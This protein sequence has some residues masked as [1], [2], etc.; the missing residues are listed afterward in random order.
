M[1][2]YVL[3][4]GCVSK[5]VRNITD[6]MCRM[7]DIFMKEKTVRYAKNVR[8]S[9][10]PMHC[11]YMESAKQSKRLLR[12]HTEILWYFQSLEVTFSGGECLL[13]AQNVKK[14]AEI[15]KQKGIHICIDTALN[16][17][18]DTIEEILPYTDL[19]LVDIKAGTEETHRKYTGVTNR[20]IK[21]N[22]KKL[23][24]E[25]DIWI[26]IPMVHHVNDTEE[27]LNEMIEFISSLGNGVK[28]IQLLK[29]H[30]LGKMKYQWIG[31]ECVEFEEPDELYREHI[32]SK[33]RE[34]PF[35]VEWN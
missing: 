30:S 29:Y 28:K 10:R 14:T 23:S 1:K 12:K 33:M 22:L 19:F 3:D 27:E 4:V 5:Y 35:Y 24:Q 18:W 8:N 32:L 25:A 2:N 17:A 31:K 26:R 11:Q 15:L 34:L 21:E 9:V 6:L 20:M 16:V 7:A 13:Q